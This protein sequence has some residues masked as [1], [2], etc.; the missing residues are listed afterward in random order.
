MPAYSDVSGVKVPEEQLLLHLY[1]A[2]MENLKLETE[3]VHEPG[4]DQ[5]L[6]R[7][8]AVGVCASDYKLIIQ[9][10]KHTRVRGKDLGADPV[11]PGHEVAMTVVKVGTAL[12]DRY[13]PGER[14]TVQAD[15]YIEGVNKAYGYWFPGAFR[16][17]QLVGPEIY[18]GGYLLAIP[19]GLGYSQVAL[20]EPWACVLFAYEKH[21]PTKSVL[22]G[23]TAWYVGAGPIGM[24]HVEK[25]IADGAARLVVSE[26][27][28][29]RL[30]RA[31]A[32]LGPLAARKGAELVIVDLKQKKIQ[33]I[34]KPGDV[35]DVIVVAP[36]ASAVEQ[37]LELVGKDGYI[38]VFAGFPSRDVA[39]ANV[40]LN[41]MHYKNVTMLAT[42]GS[43][44]SSL[45]RVLELAA[46]G[47]IDPNNSVAAVGGMKAARDGIEAVHTGAYPGKIVIYPQLADLPLVSTDELTGGRLW[48][49]AEEAKL[50]KGRRLRS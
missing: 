26:L 20:A 38:N 44:I 27:N 9:G 8:D 14:Y 37:A 30:A 17:W 36:V 31:A 34:L 40:N 48:T 21:R 12:R 7:T 4:P 6:C 5:L 45:K 15:I 10:E 42:S 46:A 39:F 41:D 43:P 16:Q 35:D 1:S 22:P 32:A 13:R 19:E 25:G 29:E 28:D 3:G 2:G 18:G 11:V 47:D 23:G 50:L 24:M 33:D 49:A